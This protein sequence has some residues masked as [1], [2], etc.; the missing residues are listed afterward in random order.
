L[1][2]EER[3]RCLGRVFRIGAARAEAVRAQ[4][5]LREQGGYERREA[6]LFSPSD[7]RSLGSATFYIATPSNPHWLGPAS[8][9]EV[10]RQVSRCRGP[11]G[12]NDEY[13]LRLHH[14][15]A[16]HGERDAETDAIVEAM[17]GLSS[18]V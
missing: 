6:E 4:L 13:L 11:S 15:L 18:L 14:W 9:H 3:G 10:A 12:A 7:G 1:V 8:V 16:T 5:D 17:E 2:A